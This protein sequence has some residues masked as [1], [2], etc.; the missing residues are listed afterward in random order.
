MDLKTYEAP[1]PVGAAFI[2]SR[3]PIDII[4]GPA[5]SGKTV[6]ST[7]KGPWA[8]VNWF[9]V[10]KDGVI[11]VKLAAIRDTY[12]D[13]ARTCLASWYEMFPPSHP[14]TVSHEGGQDR[15]VR[16]RLEWATIRENSRV[17]VEFQIEF[18]AIGDANLEA[19]IKGYQISLGWGNEC[20]LLHERVLPLLLQRTGRYPAVD[21]ISPS[22]LDRVTKDYRAMLQRLGMKI[23]DEETLL[24][25]CVWG[26]MNPPDIA[27]WSY[28]NCVEKELP[29]WKLFKQPSGLSA[30]AENRKGKP[31]SSYE[32]EASTM[33]EYDVR[34]YVHGEFGYARDTQPVYPEF[35]L[36]NHVADENLKPVQ[37]IP[38][39][40]GL[41]AGGSPAGTIGQ[42]LPNGQNRVLREICADPG[43]GPTRFGETFLE[44]LASD[45]AGFAIGEAF[46][47]PSSF[48]GADRQ[49]GEL[50][51]VEIVARILNVSIMPAPSNEPALRHDA[52][53]WYL[54]GFIDGNTPRYLIDPRCKRLIGGFAAHYKL[55]KQA[56][57]GQTDR[58]MV[59]KNEFSHVHDGEQYRCLGHRGR[60]GVIGD[61]SQLGR[62][63]NVVSI[64]SRRVRSDFNVWD[65]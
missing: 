34:R 20:D 60:Q 18:G 11:R 41:D 33:S 62:A 38:L 49:A 13:L 25:R 52:V 50:A 19:F 31:R 53:R 51:W 30:Q 4:M 54:T 27:H 63:K 26:D 39:S 47:D 61:V 36:Q 17:K 15:P 22:E 65:S 43:T 6:A 14:F 64:Q 32:M 42:F 10:C 5:G 44:V 16:H 56:S 28:V 37:G 29:G 57:A 7:V 48:Y 23:D 35:S 1:G 12:R 59:A 55:T 3:G 58:L 9:P 45:F 2:E 40:I 8:A 46:A 24:P 21:M